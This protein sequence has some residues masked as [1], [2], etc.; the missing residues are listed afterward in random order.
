M[1]AVVITPGQKASDRLVEVPDPTPESGEALIRVLS[2][3]V[4]GTDDELVSGQYGQAPEGDDQLIIG[5]ESLGRVVE[6]AGD[7]PA[8]Q[9]VA[10][11]VRRPDPVPCL[12]CAHDEW[13]YCLN[14]QYTE[15][16]I[17]GQ[18]GFL[19]D[20]YTE[21]PKYLVRVPDELERVGMLVEPTTIAVKALEQVDVI[22]RRLTWDPKRALVTGAGP[23]GLLAAAVLALRG[24]EVVVYNRSD[25]GPKV[26]LTRAIGA[27]YVAAGSV[28]FGHDLARE[29]GPFDLAI[30]ATG[31]SPLAFR[32]LDTVGANGVAVL[33]GVSGGDRVAELPVDHLNLEAVL[34]NKVLVGT[35]NAD[36][37]NFERAV[38]DLAGIEQRWPGWLQRMITLRVP[39]ERYSEALHRGPEDVKAV[40]DVAAGSSR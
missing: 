34:Q 15:R 14:G 35:V 19:A 9:L 40:V 31:F 21:Q 1:R 26:D 8:G 10:A 12:N 17:K 36:R 13:D 39:L 38:A 5:H 33:T 6:P 23:I 30:E 3:G 16:G 18:H 2:V 29:H 27:E 24:L 22:Q 20:Y 32:L 25:R 7:L 28:E 4:D 37:Q 11:I